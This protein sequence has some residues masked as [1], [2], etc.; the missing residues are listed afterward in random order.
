MTL[1]LPLSGLVPI[2]TQ[3]YHTNHLRRSLLPIPVHVRQMRAIPFHCLVN[4]HG[5]QEHLVAQHRLRYVLSLL[6]C[7]HKEKAGSE[8]VPQCWMIAPFIRQRPK[9]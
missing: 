2:H 1:L 5:A 6:V 8:S 4:L 9:C 3:R 7:R